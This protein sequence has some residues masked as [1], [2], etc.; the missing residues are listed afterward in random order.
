MDETQQSP[1]RPKEPWEPIGVRHYAVAATNVA[2]VG[3]C[4]TPAQS[5]CHTLLACLI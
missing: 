4:C 1:S 2:P 3:T 5:D